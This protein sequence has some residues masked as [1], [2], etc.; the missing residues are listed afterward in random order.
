MGDRLL[1]LA[2][3]MPEIIDRGQVTWDHAAKVLATEVS[4]DVAL[5]REAA[6]KL[7]SDPGAVPQSVALLD[8]AA[9]LAAL[10]PPPTPGRWPP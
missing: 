5:L 2:Q 10:P 7:R 6:L 9:E 1:Q 3:M 4:E 8:R